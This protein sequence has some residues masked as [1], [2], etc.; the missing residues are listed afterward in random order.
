MPEIKVKI[1]WDKPK[2]KN[3]LNNNNIV[4]ALSRYCKNTKFDVIE[5]KDKK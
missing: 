4:V 3:W 5:L 1:K 2:D